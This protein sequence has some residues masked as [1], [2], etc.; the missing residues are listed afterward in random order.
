MLP[1]PVPQPTVY[2]WTF[3]KSSVNSR[4]SERPRCLL[5]HLG[6]GEVLRGPL[7]RTLA[8]CRPVRTKDLELCNQRSPFEPWHCP[9]ALSDVWTLIGQLQVWEWEV[10]AAGM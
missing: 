7:V 5:A 8:G 2:P 9:G 10:A 4:V 1:G 3:G 6:T